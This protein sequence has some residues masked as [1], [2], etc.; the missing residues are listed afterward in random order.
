[1]KPSAAGRRQKETAMPSDA[2]PNSVLTEFASQ[3]VVRFENMLD[4]ERVAGAR[5][6]VLRQMEK[7]G[8]WQ[9]GAWR[10]DTRPK[11]VW[12]AMGIKPAR[13]IGHRHAEV[14]ALIEDPALLAVVN[15]LLN[16]RPLDSRLHPRPQILVSLPNADRWHLPEG[17][18]VDLPRLATGGSTGVQLFTF[19]EPV[20]PQGG[21]TVVIAGSH[22]LW[23]DRGALRVKDIMRLANQEPFFRALQSMPVDVLPEGRVGDVPLRVVELTGRPGDVWLIDLRLFHSAAPNISARPRMMVTHRFTP[24]DLMPEIAQA[25]G[26]T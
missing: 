14:E 22:R 24:T 23:N 20:E 5:A 2:V 8:L 25:F 21:G 26:W 10:L 17:W 12:P 15:R 13:D 4:P 3:G 11:P 9:D 16:D 6:A 19:L 18:H 7:L 1:V